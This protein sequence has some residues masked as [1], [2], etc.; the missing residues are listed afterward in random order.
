MS[1]KAAAAAILLAQMQA[2]FRY[3]ERKYKQH[4]KRHKQHSKIK[5]AGSSGKIVTCIREV[6]V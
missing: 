2:G 6:P 4:D 1:Y 5:Q 3:R